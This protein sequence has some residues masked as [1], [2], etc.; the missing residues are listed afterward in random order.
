MTMKTR[1][2]FTLIELLLVIALLAIVSTLAVT[3]IGNLRENA[4]RKISVANMQAAG[5][6]IDAFTGAAAQP[7]D[8][9]DSLVYEDSADPAPGFGDFAS[10]D[11]LYAGP[12]DAGSPLPDAVAAKNSG[13]S[14]ALR[15]VLCGYSLSKGDAG[16]LHAFGL[17]RVRQFSEKT[18]VDRTRAGDDGSFP[19]YGD[20]LDPESAACIVRNVTNGM[21]VAAVTGITD[22]G[23]LIYR[24]CGADLPADGIGGAYDPSKARAEIAAAGGPLL[25]F[26]FGD[27]ATIVGRAGGVES[28]PFSE[29]ADRRHYRRYVVLIRLRAANGATT[30]EFAGILDP[31]GRTISR[32]RAFID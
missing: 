15:E 6:A 3:R 32:A 24:E 4:A 19:V 2:G 31:E 20:G 17:R 9:L 26:G 1:S 23:R 21:V 18:E 12:A 10:A 27:G 30:A 5:R 14:P 28:A 7:L 16:A 25:A 29:A 11:A 22:A 13:L 8:L